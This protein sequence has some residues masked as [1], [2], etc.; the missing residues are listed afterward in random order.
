MTS[1]DE[2][3]ATSCL[4]DWEGCLCGL[5]KDHEP[6]HRCP[7]ASCGCEWTDEQS[8]EWWRKLKRSRE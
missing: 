7:V 8:D 3:V 2:L 6:P 1:L 5:P 4:S